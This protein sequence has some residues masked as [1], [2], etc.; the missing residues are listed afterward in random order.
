[1]TTTGNCPKCGYSSE[2]SFDECPTCRI[3]I[4]EFIEAQK[5]QE[6]QKKIEELERK[7]VDK[8]K[9]I[10]RKTNRW[11]KKHKLNKVAIFSGVLVLTLLCGY[12]IKLYLPYLF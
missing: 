11:F 6:K 10:K 7:I 5:R 3:I 8:E 1:M 12:G 2:K 9:E 4:K